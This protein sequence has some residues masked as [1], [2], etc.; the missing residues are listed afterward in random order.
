[1]LLWWAAV[2]LASIS[3]CC[4]WFCSLSYLPRTHANLNLNKHTEQT[5][6]AVVRTWERDVF[7]L[8]KHG[9]QGKGHS[10][11]SPS[12]HECNSMEMN[13]TRN[14]NNSYLFLLYPCCELS[15][16]PR[17][18][19]LN[20]IFPVTT[21]NLVLSINNAKDWH[22][23][24]K[25]TLCLSTFHFSQGEHCWHSHCLVFVWQFCD[26]CSPAISKPVT[27]HWLS[28]HKVDFFLWHFMHSHYP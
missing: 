16:L 18:T 19:W 13:G 12:V 24:T 26:S 11:L 17:F 22:T 2:T 27:D 9:E 1:M 8:Q 20:L 15:H 5:G 25:Y 23:D 14:I 21:V 3:T 7:M 28:A 4:I 10:P 6:R